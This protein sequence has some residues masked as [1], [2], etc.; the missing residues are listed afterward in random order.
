MVLTFDAI[1]SLC[2]A[3]SISI[4]FMCPLLLSLNKMMKPPWFNLSIFVAD[5]NQWNEYKTIVMFEKL[6]Y[7]AKHS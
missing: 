1:S 6:N 5:I 3:I 2:T 7:I 4:K